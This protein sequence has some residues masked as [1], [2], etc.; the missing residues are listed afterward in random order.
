MKG[1]RA[2]AAVFGLAL[3]GAVFSPSAKADAWDKKTVVT[4]SAPVRTP[5]VHQ[6][7]W[8]V[9]PAGTYVFKVM[10][11]T[12]NRHIVQIFSEDEST[13][14]ATVLAIPNVRLKP[15]DKTVVTFREQPTGQPNAMRAWFYPGRQWG[16]EFVYPKAQAVELAK[17]SGEAVL[18][19]P[20]SVT[21]EA[22]KPEASAV[23]SELER[24]PVTAVE[25]TGEEVELSQIVT[26]PPAGETLVAE[27]TP[28]A[29]PKSGSPLPLM[30]VLGLLALGGALGLRVVETRVR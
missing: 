4:F 7:G 10:A 21:T 12:G 24:T 14:Y 1:L 13:I 23:V 11:S 30:A 6:P 3:M 20:A 27:S 19:M 5:G 25:P 22:V 26:P 16:E 18:E 2:V 28:A 9:L 8:E 15:A 17:V 29:L